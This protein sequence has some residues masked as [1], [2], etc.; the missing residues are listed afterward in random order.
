MGTWEKRSH[1]ERTAG[2]IPFLKGV[3]ASLKSTGGGGV[4]GFTI[5]SAIIIVGNVKC[6]TFLLI[7]NRRGKHAK[8]PNPVSTVRPCVCN[9][10]SIKSHGYWYEEWR[11]LEDPPIRSVPEDF[12]G[13]HQDRD[14]DKSDFSLYSSGSQTVGRGRWS[15]PRK[16]RKI[17]IRADWHRSR[18]FYTIF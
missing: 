12:A 16:G 13:L 7:L 5:S 8:Y 4:T 10:I 14:S 1:N 3:E 15:K 2:D 6:L 9:A 18:D 11:N 17:W